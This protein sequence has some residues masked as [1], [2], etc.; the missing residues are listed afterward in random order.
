MHRTDDIQARRCRPGSVAHP[1]VHPG[2]CRYIGDSSPGR[3][4]T[5]VDVAV[6][7]ENDAVSSRGSEVHVPC[8]SI[9]KARILLAHILTGMYLRMTTK[10]AARCSIAEACS[11]CSPPLRLHNHRYQVRRG[12]CSES[13]S[14]PRVARRTGSLPRGRC[15]GRSDRRALRGISCPALPL[16]RIW[17]PRSTA[18][19]R[20]P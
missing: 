14:S 12:W 11:A 20:L 17:P 8:G 19:I 16:T 7:L 4:R 9:R 15:R 6:G 10:R 18:T 2:E 3:T 5:G 13:R 1:R